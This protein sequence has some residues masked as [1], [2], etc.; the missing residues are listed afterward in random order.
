MGTERLLLADEAATAALGARLAKRLAPGDVVLLQGGLGAGKTVLARALVRTL[1]SD[2]ELE[3]PS[4][5][6]ALV[7]PYEGN[8]RLVLHAD[9]YRIADPRE[10][11]EL[12]L[13]DQPEAIV[14]VEWPERDDE[15]LSRRATLVRMSLPADGR[16][17][18]AEIVA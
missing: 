9:L 15:L 13:F 12:G 7:Q 3:V 18:I 17:R 5:S 8:G 6:F 16:G 14:L 11:D 10:V 1:M 2:P 4:P